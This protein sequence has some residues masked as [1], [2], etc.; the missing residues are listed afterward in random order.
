M[1]KSLDQIM[2][3]MFSLLKE[4]EKDLQLH[5]GLFQ[6]LLQ[7][8]DWSFVIKTHALI[9]AAVSQQLAIALDERLIDIFRHLELG[10]VRS[11][12]IVFAESLGLLS[13]EECR[14]I[15]KLSEL[16]NTL[17]HDIR[18]TDFSFRAY[19]DALDKN[20]KK[21]FLDW[22]A[23]FSTEEARDQWINNAKENAKIPIWLF[24]IRLVMHTSL[25]KIKATLDRDIMKYAYQL[26]EI[27]QPALPYENNR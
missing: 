14:Y 18:K 15:Q 7:E 23:G 11:G 21:S 2:K 16:R 6:R 25:T 3:A 17:V 10:D 19:F 20:Q 13:K 26:M 24:A 4:S 22:I 12:K 27:E 8:D 9:E 1:S 5:E